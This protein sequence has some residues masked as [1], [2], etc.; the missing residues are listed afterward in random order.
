MLVQGGIVVRANVA[1][2]KNIL[3]VFEEGRI[4]RHHVFKMAV[5]RAIL[6]HEDFAIALDHL[7]F[8]FA[9]FIGV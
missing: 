1:A 9:G 2:R 8:D 5:N 4:D 3:Q 7:R 6:H